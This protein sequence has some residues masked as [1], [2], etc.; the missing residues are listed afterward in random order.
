MNRYIV[1]VTTATKLCSEVNCQGQGRC[2]RKR[3]NEDVYLHLDPMRYQILQKRRGGQLTVSGGVSQEDFNFFDRNFDC[4]CYSK[5][6][7]KSDMFNNVI[8]DNIN[9]FSM[10]S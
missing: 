4:M 3:W 2:V 5:Q 8:H 6:P 7:C 1:N 9:L 10:R